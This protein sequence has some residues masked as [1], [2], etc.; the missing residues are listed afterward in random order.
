MV[1][2][3]IFV[4][5]DRGKIL[6]DRNYRGNVSKSIV[7]EQFKKILIENEDE[8]IYSSPII[9]DKGVAFCFIKYDDIYLLAVTKSNCNT[10]LILN[11]LYKIV[12][13]FNDY[14]DGLDAEVI[15]DNFVLI[16][17]LFDE[18][19]DFGYPQHTEFKLL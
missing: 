13:V 17:E 5:D 14:F 7:A 9:I 11:F 8:Y 18:M 4:T 2:S 10:M 3:S 16:Y 15:R 12:S 1:A 19:M 6:I